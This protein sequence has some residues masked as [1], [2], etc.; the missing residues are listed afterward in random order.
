MDASYFSK[1]LAKYPV[2]RRS[3]HYKVAIK[4]KPKVNNI[5]CILF[6]DK[7]ISFFIKFNFFFNNQNQPA[8]IKAPPAKKSNLITSTKDT[9]TDIKK[10]FWEHLE[11]SLSTILNRQEAKVFM[12]AMRKVNNIFYI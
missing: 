1:E 4:T 7:Y 10:P 2:I 9:T 8:L 3:D 11:S 5:I 6:N 12:D